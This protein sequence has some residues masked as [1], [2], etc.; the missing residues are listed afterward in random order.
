M[1][2]TKNPSQTLSGNIYTV[3]IYRYISC[4]LKQADI[5]SNSSIALQFVFSGIGPFAG[6][7][8]PKGKLSSFGQKADEGPWPRRN[9]GRVRVRDAFNLRQNDV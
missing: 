9:S 3:Y 4:C 8:L 2:F 5:L 6:F 1:F 7:V